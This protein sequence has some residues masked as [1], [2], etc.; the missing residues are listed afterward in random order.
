LEYK[1]EA[2]KRLTEFCQ[3]NTLDHSK[4]PLPAIQAMTPYIHGHHQM[5]STE[6][7]LNIFFVAED[8]EALY[9]QQK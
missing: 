9:R 1:N 8:G 5:V 3:E 6:I 4:H 7:R 2:G